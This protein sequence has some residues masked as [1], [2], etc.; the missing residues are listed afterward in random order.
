M[1]RLDLPPGALVGRDREF[2]F[3][4]GFFQ[5][6]AV[7]GGAVLLSGEPGVGKTALLN[8]LADSASAAGTTVLRVAGAEFEG[9]ISFAGL[10]Q[11]LFPLLDD[12]DELDADHR[13]ALASIPHPG[14]PG[15]P[16]GRS[17]PGRPRRCSPRTSSTPAPCCYAA[18]MCCSSSSTA[19][20]ACTWP[21]SPPTP[22]AS[23]SPSRPVIC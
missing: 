20:G 8:G 14:G 5:E 2:G 16:G 18:C 1:S 3:L 23:G 12:L 13:D 17:W 9:E 4:Q 21:G 15:R 22:R 11:L 10:N 7:S 6:A 19:P